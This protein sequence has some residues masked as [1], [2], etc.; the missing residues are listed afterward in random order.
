MTSSDMMPTINR[1]IL[2]K[3]GDAEEDKPLPL[4]DT[5][6]AEE[7]KITFLNEGYSGNEHREFTTLN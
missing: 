2:R 7:D 4:L 3:T 1:A 6:L 5:F